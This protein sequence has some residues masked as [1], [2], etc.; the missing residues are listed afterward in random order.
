MCVSENESIACLT[1][2]LLACQVTRCSASTNP[3]PTGVS[4]DRENITYVASCQ[5]AGQRTSFPRTRC[6]A[7]QSYFLQLADGEAGELSV[8]GRLCVGARLHGLNPW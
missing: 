4:E 5:V 7:A 2:S 6:K 3:V 8:V 1:G